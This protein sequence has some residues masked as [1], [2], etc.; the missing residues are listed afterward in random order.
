MAWKYQNGDG[1]HFF[2]MVPGATGISFGMSTSAVKVIAN[3]ANN[4]GLTIVVGT[5]LGKY[6]LYF[7]V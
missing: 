4:L 5:A 2:C 7:F 3:L 6:T 1:S